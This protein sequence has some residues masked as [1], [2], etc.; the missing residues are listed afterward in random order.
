M[1]GEW[2]KHIPPKR[3]IATNAYVMILVNDSPKFTYANGSCGNVVEWEFD[4]YASKVSI[5]LVTGKIVTIGYCTRKVFSKFQ[6]DD[7]PDKI[8]YLYKYELFKQQYIDD[9]KEKGIELVGL[10]M[11]MMLSNFKR[12]LFDLTNQH[13][14]EAGK[15]KPYFDYEEGKWVIAEICYM[16][17]DFA[18]AST[19]H[20]TQGLSLDRIQIDTYNPFIG[21]PAMMYVAMSR[22]RSVEGLKIVGTPSDVEDKINACV[23]VKEWM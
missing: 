13:K 16:P 9:A 5:K 2:E 14:E 10:D 20:K 12:Y 11:S 4:G 17:L 3:L 6:P 1:P 21:D 15:G 18:W 19:V 7:A 23:E 22:A 8:D